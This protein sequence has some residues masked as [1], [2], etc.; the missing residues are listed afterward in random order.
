MS[1]ESSSDRDIGDDRE[2]GWLFLISRPVTSRLEA[3]ERKHEAQR[4]CYGHCLSDCSLWF[5]F[6]LLREGESSYGA[7]EFFCLR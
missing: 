5:F 6:T 2:L 3:Y 1:D 7:I 4:C